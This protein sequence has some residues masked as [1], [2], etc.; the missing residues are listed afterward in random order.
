MG[1]VDEK[2]DKDTS[3]FSSP[4]VARVPE[5]CLSQKILRKLKLSSMLLLLLWWWCWWWW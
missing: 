1:F 4:F 5:K 3:S 2:G